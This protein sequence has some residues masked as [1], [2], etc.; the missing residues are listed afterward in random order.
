M[1]KRPGECL[2]FL[3]DLRL[4]YLNCTFHPLDVYPA[5]MSVP[6]QN[7]KPKNKVAISPGEYEYLIQPSLAGSP[8]LRSPCWMAK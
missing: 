5:G 2:A 1:I 3:F 4:S 7:K 6:P 8:S